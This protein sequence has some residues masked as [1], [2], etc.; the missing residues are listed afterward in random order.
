MREFLIN[1]IDTI[2]Y[3]LY[4]LTKED[5]TDYISKL[6]K[7]EP[8]ESQTV[9]VLA[10]GPSLNE[11]ISRIEAEW[12]KYA[13]DEF[14]GVNYIADLESYERLK[15]KY[16]A[17][18]DP[19][20]FC[21][22]L[23]DKERVENMYMNMNE[24]TTWKMYLFIPYLYYKTF[25]AITNSNIVVVPLHTRQYIGF[26]SLRFWYYRRGLGNGE[27]GTVV[28][29]AEYALITKGYKHINL[30]GVEHNYFNGLVVTDNNEFCYRY[31]H[32]GETEAKL[33]P[34]SFGAHYG[35]R[36]H[37]FMKGFGYLFEGH[38]ILNR[39]AQS[40]GCEI[41]NCTKGSFIDSYKRFRV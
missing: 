38:D 7:E 2:F 4:F 35:I 32:I 26:E 21:E 18:S 31:L 37:H 33:T 13:G 22:G 25:K 36:V 39:Y 12:D 17:L 8:G 41:L 6:C 9:H 23:P 11:S 10:N 1:I 27:F 15:P 16:Y 24:R 30:Y 20:F 3:F 29:N 34:V 19:K 40:V 28:Q 5:F 14:C